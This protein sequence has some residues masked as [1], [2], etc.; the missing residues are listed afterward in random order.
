M[1]NILRMKL[2]DLIRVRTSYVYKYL[3]VGEILSKALIHY[4]SGYTHLR[5][6]SNFYLKWKFYVKGLLYKSMKNIFVRTNL[7]PH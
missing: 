2:F 6:Y 3:V 7:Q 4:I 1:K 5:L